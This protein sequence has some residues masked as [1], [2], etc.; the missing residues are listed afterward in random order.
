MCYEQYPAWIILISNF[1]SIAI[2]LIGAFV[3][4]KLGLVW[5]LAYLAYVL[6]LEIRVVSTHCVN[7]CYYGKSCA[8]AKGRLSAMFFKKG[9]PKEF[10]KAEMTWKDILPDFL[11]SIIPLIAGIVLLIIK[12]DSILLLLLILLTAFTFSGNAFVRQNLACKH[13]KQKKLGCP[14]QK[15]FEKAK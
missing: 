12:F 14:A 7:C 2:Y 9:N 15:L 5:L 8:F 3:I 11:V 10:C 13:C 4:Y 1:V 6:F